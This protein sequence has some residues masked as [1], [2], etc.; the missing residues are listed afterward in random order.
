MLL[1]SIYRIEYRKKEKKENI[2]KK[3]NIDGFL[4]GENE[5]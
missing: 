5:S 4:F 3:K 2:N 1:L